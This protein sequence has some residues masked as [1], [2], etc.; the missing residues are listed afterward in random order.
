MT[1]ELWGALVQTMHG[2]CVVIPLHLPQLR[3]VSVQEVVL[4]SLLLLVALHFA[5]HA[6]TLPPHHWGWGGEVGVVSV[7]GRGG[8]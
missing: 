3:T 2:A 4:C 6:P 1:C 8:R 7:G 5:C